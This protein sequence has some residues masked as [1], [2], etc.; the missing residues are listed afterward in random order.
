MI[1]FTDSNKTLSLKEIEKFELENNIKLTTQYKAFLIQNN[2]GY[3]EPSLFKISEEQGENVLNRFFS[4]DDLRD[5][6]DIYEDRIPNGFIP[7]ANDSSG[8]AICLGTREPYHEKIYFWDHEQE[9]ENPEAM[10]NMYFLANDIYQFL[11]SLY[12]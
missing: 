12:E 1:E 3:P 5:Y 10:N 7:I 8:N 9:S 6:I 2:G 4:I 11:E